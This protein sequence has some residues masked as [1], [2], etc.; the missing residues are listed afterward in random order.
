M[1]M[2]CSVDPKNLCSRV[3]SRF[4][5]RPSFLLG[6]ANHLDYCLQRGPAGAEPAA[7]AAGE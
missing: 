4:C 2:R 5:H 3:S 1:C 7:P 6:Q